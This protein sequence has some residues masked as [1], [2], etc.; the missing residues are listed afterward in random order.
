MPPAASFLFL[1]GIGR[2]ELVDR[3]RGFRAKLKK[4]EKKPRQ[5]VCDGV[6]LRRLQTSSSRRVLDKPAAHL[7]TASQDWWVAER[8]VGGRNQL[9][10]EKE[11]G[12]VKHFKDGNQALRLPAENWRDVSRSL[13]R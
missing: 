12:S 10:K 8:M 5:N 2:I 3:V 1:P 7:N 11:S 9:D 13:S 6:V 4:V